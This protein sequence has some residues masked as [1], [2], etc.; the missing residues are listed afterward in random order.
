MEELGDDEFVVLPNNKPIGIKL[1]SDRIVLQV[2]YECKD[3]ECNKCNSSEC[4]I[5]K[6]KSKFYK[7]FKETMN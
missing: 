1:D 5:M 7:S 4:S 6:P 2:P 3:C